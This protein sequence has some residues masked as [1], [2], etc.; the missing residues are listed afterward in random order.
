MNVPGVGATEERRA[1][2]VELR[3][4]DEVHRRRPSV[5]RGDDLGPDRGAALVAGVL[6]ADPANVHSLEQERAVAGEEGL[7]LAELA[8]ALKVQLERLVQLLALEHLERTL[9]R[10]ILAL[11]LLELG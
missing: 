2:E 10:R 6:V 4:R 7:L 9:E 8:L 5:E 3:G 11:G 1:A